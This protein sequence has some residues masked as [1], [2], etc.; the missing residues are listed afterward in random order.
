METGVCGDSCWCCPRYIATNSDNEALF[1]ELLHL[2]VKAGLRPVGT[3]AE[4]LR[5]MGCKTVEQCVNY[6]VK[7][8]AKDRGLD[9][10]GKCRNYPCTTI[11]EVFK[12]SGEVKRKMTEALTEYEMNL[13]GNAF[14][15]KKENLD[16]IN[17]RVR[18]K[19]EK[20]AGK[21]P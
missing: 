9:S 4:E 16:R 1:A 3:K 19:S 2:Y 7:A 5:C 10:C 11:N 18:L 20:A 21:T 8:C 14:F 17:Q 6:E 12:K 13:F 15:R